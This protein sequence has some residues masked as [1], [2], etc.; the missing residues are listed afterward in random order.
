MDVVGRFF[1]RVE[2]AAKGLVPFA[3]KLDS[4]QK[5]YSVFLTNSLFG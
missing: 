3:A 1:Q 2:A 5:G 4:A